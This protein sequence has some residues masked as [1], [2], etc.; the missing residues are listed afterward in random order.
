M[1]GTSDRSVLIDQMAR[2]MHR[3]HEGFLSGMLTLWPQDGMIC[4]QGSSGAT[5]VTLSGCLA[6]YLTLRGAM[7]K[8]EKAWHNE[9][10]AET[11]PQLGPELQQAL[12]RKL[13]KRA[14]SGAVE[15]TKYNG[16]LVWT[17]MPGQGSRSLTVSYRYSR[18]LG[19]N[20]TYTV[21]CLDWSR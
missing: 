3:R 6:E 12:P 18:G 14:G 13:P 16:C 1:F 7:A 2:R 17:W 4:R 8:I 10:C 5:N 20:P 11:W 19:M 21:L 15:S 9:D